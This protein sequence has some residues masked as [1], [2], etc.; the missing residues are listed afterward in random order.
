MFFTTKLHLQFYFRSLLYGQLCL[1]ENAEA[2]FL[3]VKYRFTY[4][5]ILVVV[6]YTCLF[7]FFKYILELSLNL[8]DN[9]RFYLSTQLI[10]ELS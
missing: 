5:E 10:F 4:F 9:E 3:K 2:C 8:S 6:A 1:K 7:L